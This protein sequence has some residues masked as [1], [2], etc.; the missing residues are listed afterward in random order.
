[1]GSWCGWAPLGEG[2]PSRRDHD[3]SIVLGV[4]KAIL[5]VKNANFFGGERKWLGVRR[6][7]MKIFLFLA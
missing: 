4:E 1:M 7:G 2:A 3:L 5:S 6:M